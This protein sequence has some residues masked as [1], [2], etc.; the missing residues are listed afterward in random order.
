MT[1]CLPF[2]TGAHPSG[3]SKYLFMITSRRRLGLVATLLLGC[4]ITSN[5]SVFAQS[6]P[7]DPQE[8]PDVLRV[9]TEIVQTDVMVFDK[10]GKFV[11]DLR[12]EDFELRIDGKLLSVEF[13][14]RITTGSGNEELQLAAARGRDNS[15]QGVPGSVVPLD[16]GRTIFF[17]IDDLHLDQSSATLTRQTITRFLERDMGQNDEVAI[18]SSSG[19][20]GFLQQLT[21]NLTVLRKAL[22]KFRPRA[23]NLSDS[24]H[25]PMKEYQALLISSY[26]RDTTDFFVEQLLRENQG[27]RRETA[28]SMVQSRARIRL[29]ESAVATRNTLIGLER[30]V[31]S[32]RELPGRKIIFF[33][34]NGFVVDS[35]NSDMRDRLQRVTSAA[36]RSG[37]VIYSLDARGLVASL[38]DISVSMPFDP[39]GRYE[40]SLNG[41]LFANQDAMNA[42]AADTGGRAFFNTNSFEPAVKRALAETSTY[43]LL[44]WKPE[45]SSSPNKSRFRKIEVKLLNKPDLTVRVRRG[46]YETEPSPASAEAKKDEKASQKPPSEAA[47]LSSVIAAPFPKRT[48]PVSLSLSYLNTP[49]KG[50]MLSTSL[51]VPH[52]FVTFGVGA[53]KTKAAL[54]V[55]GFIYDEAGRVGA[56]FGERITI[57]A[58]E[59]N[60]DGPA[61]EKFISSDI[62]YSFPIH[63]SPGLYQVRVGAR[64]IASG[65]AGSAQ[66]WIEIPNVAGKKLAM[67]SLLIG[68]RAENLITNTSAGIPASS[69]VS[70]NVSRRFRRDSLLR[71][72]FFVYNAGL[73]ADGK[74]DAA[75]Q[76]QVVRDEQPVVTTALRK[77]NSEGITDLARLPYAA[78]MPL[79]EL[80]VGRY[81]LSVTVV[82]RVT[83]TSFTQ[84]AKFEIY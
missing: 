67:S 76:I 80:S 11:K 6:Q 23:S 40:R 72:L 44:A 1:L 17:F 84:K 51:Q 58:T 3:K 81:V 35:I 20:I 13:F 78:E 33:I 43:Y 28:V 77:I 26:D 34:S 37:V 16:R 27:M 7:Q 5:L 2:L 66:G 68:E 65:K 12:R 62:T 57:T 83:K 49:D 14:E 50:E 47:Q 53:N 60:A 64:D 42:L 82:D 41:E 36:A 75:A 29:A 32:S 25:P 9:F 79:K 73:D 10:D 70:L 45:S 55:A 56:K 24:E 69:E 19:Q 38:T 74:P 71:F 31:R 39:S 46:F 8:Q 4:V 22:Q 15:G 30:L 54:D 18:A 21:D 63:L 52:E 61:D 59:A 48:L